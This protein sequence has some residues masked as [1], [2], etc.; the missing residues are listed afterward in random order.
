MN[1]L[2]FI[3]SGLI[4]KVTF[5]RVLKPDN[6]TIVHRLSFFYNFN[7]YAGLFGSAFFHIEMSRNLSKVENYITFN[8]SSLFYDRMPSKGDLIVT[9]CLPY[10]VEIA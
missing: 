1:G 2:I 4:I 6:R 7:F 9:I 8:L 5:S 3:L 10:S